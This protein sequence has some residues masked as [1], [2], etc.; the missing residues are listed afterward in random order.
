MFPEAI[1]MG[2]SADEFWHGSPRWFLSYSEAYKRKMEREEQIKSNFAD[3]EAWLTGLYVHQAVGVV[4]QNGFSKGR[5]GKYVKEPISFS[6]RK[7]K[8]KQ[9]KTDEAQMWAQFEGFK[10]LTDTMNGGL[11]KR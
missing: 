11:R 3:Y 8:A 4:L 1:I 2:M 5:K 7:E 6:Q 10:R 9:K